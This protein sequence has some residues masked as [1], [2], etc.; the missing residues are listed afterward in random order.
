MHNLGLIYAKDKD[1]TDALS[2][3]TD[4]INVRRKKL[5]ENSIY[6]AETLYHFANT[7]KESGDTI[8]ALTSFRE[9][10]QICSRL[11]ENNLLLSCCHEIG[12]IK[13]QEGKE[14]DALAILTEAWTLIQDGAMNDT[15]LSSSILYHLGSIYKRRSEYE[16]AL[17]YL[18][19]CLQI[20]MKELGEKNIDAANTCEEIGSVLISLERYDDSLKILLTAL[21]TYDE[22]LEKDDINFATIHQHLGDVYSK[23]GEY[24]LALKQYKDCFRIYHMNMGE[25]SEDIASIHI[26]M[27]SITDKVSGK[28]QIMS[29]LSDLCILYPRTYIGRILIITQPGTG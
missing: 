5:D 21:K 2:M 26:R 18:R 10:R 24:D 7:L 4:A 8:R 12:R 13:V 6:I 29:R 28:S 22:V 25:Q 23:K 1:S 20:Q 11:K 3:F 16:K 15:A 17:G 19:E 9:A 27:A 14:D